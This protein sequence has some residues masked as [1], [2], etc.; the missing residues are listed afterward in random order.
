MLLVN[1]LN[2]YNKH[3][4][5]IITDNVE[6]V[7]YNS[8]Y[9]NNYSEYKNCSIPYTFDLQKITSKKSE[10]DGCSTMISDKL[11]C[12]GKKFNSTIVSSYSTTDVRNP[13]LTSISPQD[14]AVI[15]RTYTCGGINL[16]NGTTYLR[17]VV[18]TD[19]TG[20]GYVAYDPIQ[21]TVTS[22]TT[23]TFVF[24]KTVKGINTTIYAKNTGA[25]NGA[26]YGV[27]LNGPLEINEI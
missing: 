15:G 5:V 9:Q 25:D 16:I 23:L 18:N 19:N 20:S 7:L 21:C 22:S 24:P 6:K 12:V 26:S 13:A 14:E 27:T 2:N 17:V 8:N 3:F 1:M 4:N 10:R 11:V